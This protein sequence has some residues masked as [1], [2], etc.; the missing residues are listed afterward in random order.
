MPESYNLKQILLYIDWLVQNYF[1]IQII[2]CRDNVKNDNG[3]CMTITGTTRKKYLIQGI[4][5]EAKK[6]KQ[7]AEITSE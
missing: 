6:K 5:V 7:E 3:S 2:S 1:E 4:N